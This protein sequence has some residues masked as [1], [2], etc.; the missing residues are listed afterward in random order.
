[1]QRNIATQFLEWHPHQTTINYNSNLSVD[2]S[3][4]IKLTKKQPENPK[5]LLIHEHLLLSI[6]SLLNTTGYLDWWHHSWIQL[7]L[8]VFV[9]LF[10]ITVGALL[11]GTVTKHNFTPTMQV[12]VRAVIK[13]KGPGFSPR[14]L[15]YIPSYSDIKPAC[16]LH[17]SNSNP[18]LFFKYAHL[19]QTLVS[20]LESAHVGKDEIFGRQPLTIKCHCLIANCACLVATDFFYS[21]LPC[22]HVLMVQLSDIKIQ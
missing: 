11:K 14:I 3:T 22:N 2:E 17:Y 15:R 1:M 21:T 8:Q 20:A 16:C 6:F 13:G 9:K 12:S 7:I 5:T 4:K 19:L 10:L 18:R